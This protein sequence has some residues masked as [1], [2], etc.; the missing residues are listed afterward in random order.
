MQRHGRCLV[1]LTVLDRLSLPGEGGHGGSQGRR[2]RSSQTPCTYGNVGHGGCGWQARFCA[3]E[4]QLFLGELVNV[5]AEKLNSVLN[6][7]RHKR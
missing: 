7:Q 1:T 3:L 5:I 6:A 4:W 2:T